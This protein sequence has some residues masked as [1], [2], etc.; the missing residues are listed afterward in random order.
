MF[1]GSIKIK[2]TFME[3]QTSSEE[4]FQSEEGT[5]KMRITMEYTKKKTLDEGPLT[6][7]AAMGYGSWGDSNASMPS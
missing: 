3:T 2:P 6:F 4:W 1:L 5:G 7:S